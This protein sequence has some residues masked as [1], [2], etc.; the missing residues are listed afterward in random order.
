MHKLVFEM[1][2]PS[3]VGIGAMDFEKNYGMMDQQE[4]ALARVIQDMVTLAHRVFAAADSSDQEQ[5]EMLGY[6]GGAASNMQMAMQ[7]RIGELSGLVPSEWDREIRHDLRN[8]LTALL[9]FSE[10]ILFEGSGVPQLDADLRTL[11]LY[12]KQF[13]DF[14]NGD[15]LIDP[16]AFGSIG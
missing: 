16:P 9:G 6:I 11:H 5:A 2:S 1:K 7:S 4:S 14:L 15:R 3:G 10:M 12:S 13:V 8:H